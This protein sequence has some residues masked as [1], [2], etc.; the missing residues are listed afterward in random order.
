MPRISPLRSL[1]R[2]ITASVSA[3][4]R[5]TAAMNLPDPAGSSPA[6]KPPGIIKICDWSMSFFI[7]A[8]ENATSESF[9]LRKTKVFATAPARSKARAV[10]YSQFVPGKTGMNTCG[11]AHFDGAT[12]M[13]LLAK[14]GLGKLPSCDCAASVGKIFSS[15]LLHA[16]FSSEIAI[17]VAPT[18]ISGEEIVLPTTLP[19][20]IS[21]PS[22]SSTSI[23]P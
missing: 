4:L 16:D 7:S 19:K 11:F 5:K 1:S 8:I 13:F 20:S 9:I 21:A 12:A 22:A 17:E 15:G 23:A 14:P 2:L 10:S 18:L 6:L 3:W